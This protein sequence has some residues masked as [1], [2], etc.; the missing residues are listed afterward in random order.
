MLLLDT[1]IVVDFVR[2]KSD[3]LAFV[4]TRTKA[5][6]ALCPIVVMELYQGARNRSELQR[7]KR[8]LKGFFLLDLTKEVAD[9]ALSLYETYVLSQG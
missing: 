2:Q 4:Q 1:T 3:A 6:L 8:D 9:V 5:E 7:I